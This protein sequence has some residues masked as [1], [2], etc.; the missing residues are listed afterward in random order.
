MHAL[1]GEIQVDLQEAIAARGKA[2]LVVSGGRT[3]VPL[4]AQLARESLD[5]DKVWI[6]LADERWVDP[7]NEASNERLVRT[8]LLQEEASKAHFAALKNTAAT[9]EAGAEWA[10]RALTRVPRPFD[11]VLLGMG[12]DGHT[13]SLFPGSMTLA[14][15]LDV[16]AP[17]A[18]VA[19]NTMSSPHARLS[20]NLSALLD[21][22]RIVLHIQGAKKWAVYQ[23]ARAVGSL[24]ELPVRAVLH[25]QLA[26]VDVF[27][28]P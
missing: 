19:V 16:N 25:Q 2:G 8:T 26:P 18:C 10:W 14:R 11:L 27:W 9:P 3:P 24:H 28:S 21:A 20:L 7:N 22:R 17:P 15:A 5:W 23:R 4:F 13:A 12:D 6:T 1:A